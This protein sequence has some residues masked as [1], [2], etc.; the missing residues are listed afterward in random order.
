VTSIAA[1]ARWRA[2]LTPGFT[3]RFAPAPTGWLHLGHVVNAIWVWGLARAYGGRVLLRIEDHDRGRCRLEYERG[4]LDDLDWLGLAP[5]GATTSDFRHGPHAQRQSDG[6]ARYTARLAALETER[7]AYACACSRSEVARAVGGASPDDGDGGAELR[8]PGTCRDRGISPDATLARR[9]RLDPAPAEQ[10]DD[11]RLGTQSQDPV[12]Q[13]G[14]VLAR[15]RHGNFTYQFAVVVDDLEQG[16]DV[17]IRGEDLLASTGRQLRLA[18]LLGRT[19]PPR[20]LHHPLVTHPDG[21]KL[22]KSSGDTGVRDLRSAG[23]S[24]DDVLGLAAALAGVGHDGSPLPPD[25]L[26]A[27]FA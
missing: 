12:L 19:T 6:L 4:I 23:R 3:T 18:R 20:F 24:R 15:D 26:A 21:R 7:A 1:H 11:L 5:D 10:F 2:A 16:V 13:C 17:V 25:R 8:Y 9:I 14:D 27:L 22:S